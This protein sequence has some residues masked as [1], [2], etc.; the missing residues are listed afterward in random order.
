MMWPDEIEAAKK[1]LQYKID[2]LKN[3]FSRAFYPLK[4]QKIANA[5]FPITMF[6]MSILDLF[7][8]YEAG[9]NEGDGQ[10][11]R[12]VNYLVNYM[13]YDEKASKVLVQF[14]RHQL[15]HTSDPQLIQSKND[16]SVYGWRIGDKDTYHM[17]LKKDEALSKFKNDV[18]FLHFSL[19]KFIMDIEKATNKY[20]QKLELNKQLQNNYKA[21]A[22]EIKMKKLDL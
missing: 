14:H 4:K 11:A 6:A 18:Y 7:S 9:R 8:S 1:R 10:T 12:M 3:D 17:K 13:G 2:S 21:C 5:P 20:I 15:M 19:S 22:K 16:K